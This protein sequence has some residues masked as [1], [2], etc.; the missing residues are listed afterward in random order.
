MKWRI[1]NSNHS[2][3]RSQKCRGFWIMESALAVAVIGI[4]VVAVVGSQQ[5]WH[6]QGVV[7]DRHATGMRL[8]TEIRELSLLLPANDPVTGVTTWGVE[9]SE[10]MPLDLDDLDDMDEIIFSD[11]IDATKTTITGLAGWSQQITVQCVNP[12]DVLE[13]VDDGAS[14]IVQI[15]VT[16]SFEGEE[17]TRLSWI[18]PR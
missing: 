10:V 6:M 2:Y 1:N 11:P 3:Q 7:S 8:A 17:I 9:S 14:E 16:V 13:I 18:A 15:E 12:F 4:G 5:A